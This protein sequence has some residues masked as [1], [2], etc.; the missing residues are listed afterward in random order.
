MPIGR[1]YHWTGFPST[2][3]YIYIYIYIYIHTHR[4]T[5]IS[6]SLLYIIIKRHDAFVYKN[7]YLL[8]TAM[9]RSKWLHVRKRDCYH[10]YHMG[11]IFE[12]QSRT[13]SVHILSSDLHHV[14]L[15]HIKIDMT[16][17]FFFVLLNPGR[18]VHCSRWPLLTWVFESLTESANSMWLPCHYIIFSMPSHFPSG[19]QFMGFISAVLL[20]ILR[21]WC[22]IQ[23]MK[24]ST[25]SSLRSKVNM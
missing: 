18:G 23:F 13:A 14:F 2:Q 10:W 21:H 6:T 25:T 3:Y 4:H 7:I 12:S 11:Y 15:S 19:P 16:E 22:N 24:F 8:F 20:F 5:L 17:P 1:L 9:K